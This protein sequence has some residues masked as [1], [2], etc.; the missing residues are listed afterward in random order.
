MTTA[1][2]SKKHNSKHL[3]VHQWVRSAICDSQQR[4]SPIGFL[5]LKLPPLPCAVLLVYIVSICLL[6][7]AGSRKCCLRARLARKAF[8]ALWWLTKPGQDD[9][10]ALIRKTYFRSWQCDRIWQCLTGRP[11]QLVVKPHLKP[12]RPCAQN[13]VH[14]RNFGWISPGTPNSVPFILALKDLKA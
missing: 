13:P 3:S 7:P 1:T 5:F 9:T 11:F 2:I 4:T 10:E 12:G 8:G 6:A 14:V